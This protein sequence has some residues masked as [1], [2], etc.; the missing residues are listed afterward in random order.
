MVLAGPFRFFG[1][2]GG[3]WLVNDGFGGKNEGFL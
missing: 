3:E 1:C 2:F